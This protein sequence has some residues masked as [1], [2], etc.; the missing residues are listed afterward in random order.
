LQQQISLVVTVK[1]YP[2]VSRKY[3]EAVCVAGIRT[4]TPEPE[5]VRLFPVTFRDLPFTQRFKKYQEITLE[6]SRHETDK[7]PESFRPNLD[8]LQVGGWLDSKRGWSKRRPL[9]DPLE[10]ESMCELLRR[11]RAHGTSLGVLRPA[12]VIDFEIEPDADEWD[13]DKQAALAQP[14]LLFPEKQELV[15]IPYRFRYRYR[16]SDPT[17]PTHRQSIIDWELAQSYRA[18]TRYGE[19]ERL[20]KLKAK[21]LNE[22]CHADKDTRFFVGNQH[23]YPEAFL[24]LGVF[25]PPKQT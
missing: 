2:A 3:R 21:W 18:W 17:C 16:C 4:D 14:S 7:R 9:V 19:P 8:S 22:M 5:W 6:A 12:E 10:V 20:E 1:A 15:K 13:R 23:L 24:V 25:W 11:Q